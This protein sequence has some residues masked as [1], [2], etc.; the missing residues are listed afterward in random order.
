MPAEITLDILI[1]AD[2]WDEKIFKDAAGPVLNAAASDLGLG[3][4]ELS[5]L[6]CDDA[7]IADLN[8][9]FRGKAKPTNVLSWPSQEFEHVWSDAISFEK[10]D[11]VDLEIGDLA[12]A[13]E[14]LTA[15]AEDAG[16]PFGAHLAHL[17]LHGMLHC[18]GFDHETE[19]TAQHMENFERKILA[20]C[21]LHDPYS[22]S[23]SD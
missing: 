20:R 14:T 9:Q 23:D 2:G 10:G 8:A 22:N 1:E 3:D 5:V 15:E 6:L 18:L 4:L 13:F 12:I 17:T 16:L 11:L 7:R 19:E 21:G